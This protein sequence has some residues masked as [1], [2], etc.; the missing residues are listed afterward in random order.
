[1]T[2]Q[3]REK[4]EKKIKFSS[5]PEF[6]NENSHKPGGEGKEGG[7]KKPNPRFKNPSDQRFKMGT[8]ALGEMTELGDAAEV[9]HTACGWRVSKCQM[10]KCDKSK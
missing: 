6:L 7:I 4:R 1:L 10:R 9:D 3:N 8:H 2:Q 5:L